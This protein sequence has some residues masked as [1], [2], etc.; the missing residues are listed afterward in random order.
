[1]DARCE[2][3]PA[4]AALRQSMKVAGLIGVFFLHLRSI[5]KSGG[6]D[7]ISGYLVPAGGRGSVGFNS[8]V[9]SVVLLALCH[10]AS[11]LNIKLIAGGR[12]V[13]PTRKVIC[14][15]S[16]QVDECLADRVPG[17]IR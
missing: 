6:G 9:A 5:R 2:D 15:S 11:N 10:P 14:R 17:I 13:H 12:D 16:T 4:G 3:R 8:M 1:M 7:Q